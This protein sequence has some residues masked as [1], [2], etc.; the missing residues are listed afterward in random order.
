M[1]MDIRDFKKKNFNTK[2]NLCKDYYPSK[3]R[4]MRCRRQKSEMIAVVPFIVLPET[5][6]S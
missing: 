6:N 5:D 3:S 2:P 4:D 1:K